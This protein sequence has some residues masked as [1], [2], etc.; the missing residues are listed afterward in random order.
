MK[1]NKPIKY[2]KQRGGSIITQQMKGLVPGM[3]GAIPGMTGAIPGMTQQMKGLVP[4]MTGAIPGMT[5]QMKGLVPGMT[6][7]IPGMTQG[8][9]PGVKK[10]FKSVNDISDGT[11]TT[12]SIAKKTIKKFK[13]TYSDVKLWYFTIPMMFTF[14]VSLIKFCI[15][16]ALF[17]GMCELIIFLI[18]WFNRTVIYDG[19][20]VPAKKLLGVKVK[21]PELVPHIWILLWD[22][23]MGLIKNS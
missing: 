21:K 19:L 18:N 11:N 6:G 12:I 3:T 14:I 10:L 1:K 16:Y 15:P 4:G 22:W 8:M 2:K 9:T 17:V 5:Q 13:E 20:G 7:A 23:I